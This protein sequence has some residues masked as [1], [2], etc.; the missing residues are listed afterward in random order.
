[1]PTYFN[2]RL[3]SPGAVSFTSNAPVVAQAIAV[4]A[5]ATRQKMESDLRDSTKYM[6]RRVKFH[7]PRR[8]GPTR[9]RGGVVRRRGTYATS[10]DSKM[11]RDGNWYTGE[12]GTD[13]PYGWRLERGFVG[14]D[15]RGRYY[16]QAPQPHFRP[17]FQEAQA[18]LLSDL[19]NT[20]TIYQASLFSST[21]I[22]PIRP[23]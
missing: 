11:Y 14:E 16:N 5:Q 13:E 6:E 9:K 8:K 10:I 20:L 21:G 7:A 22:R 19:S 12:A 23:L 15:S 2:T 18:K 1:M 17:G 4:T 3:N